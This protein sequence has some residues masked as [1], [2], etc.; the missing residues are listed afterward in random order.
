VQKEKKKKPA[1]FGRAPGEGS[2]RPNTDLSQTTS[3]EEIRGSDATT[4][5]EKIGAEKDLSRSKEGR[6][7]EGK[8]SVS[9]ASI[10]EIEGKGSVSAR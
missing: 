7:K 1:R 8:E 9:T 6:P 4:W 2:S 10:P 5:E 3:G